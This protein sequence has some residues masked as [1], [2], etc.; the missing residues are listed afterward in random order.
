MEMQ[1]EGSESTLAQLA[2]VREEA[3][4]TAKTGE[5]GSADSVEV[6]VKSPAA[7]PLSPAGESEEVAVA[8]AAEAEEEIRIGDQVFK[9]QREAIKYAEK[10]EQ[11]KLINEAYSSG[12]RETLRVNAPAPVAPPEEDNFEEKF[13]ANPK[14]ALKEVQM[15]ARDEAVAAIRAE[16]NRERLWV[17]FFNENPDLEGSREMCESVLNKNWE[18]LGAMTDVPKAMKLL[19]QKTR[20]IYQD[21]IDRTKPRTELPNKGGQVLSP[22]GGSPKSVTPKKDEGPIDF[23]T[24]LKRM[25]R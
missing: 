21:Y 14:E 22:S 16:T 23:V 25:R 6:E 10:L 20:A 3:N 5:G 19:A 18:T 4:V 1:T 17:Q 9:T 2:R 11:D 15:R 24:Q 8:P 7:E 12:V 13:Y